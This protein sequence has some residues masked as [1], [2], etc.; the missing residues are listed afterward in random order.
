MFYLLKHKVKNKFLKIEIKNEMKQLI[1]RK[2][3]VDA[4]CKVILLKELI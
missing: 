3:K 4:L 1:R 2:N